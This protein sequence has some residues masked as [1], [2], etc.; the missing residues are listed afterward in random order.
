MEPRRQPRSDTRA[1][2]RFSVR[3]DAGGLALHLLPCPLGVVA[4][5]LE[6]LGLSAVRLA[7]GRLLPAALLGALEGDLAFATEGSVALEVVVRGCHGVVRAP[8]PVIEAVLRRWLTTL[9]FARGVPAGL[10][11]V[12]RR[13]FEDLTAPSEGWREPHVTR[14]GLDAWTLEFRELTD[15]GAP[16]GVGPRWIGAD[17]TGW[18]T[19]WAW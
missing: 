5:A 6:D 1:R 13:A 19:D 10:D 11:A 16:R 14:A 12:R 4:D 9:L 15:D 17:D 8:A 18:R 7:D 3:G 2:P